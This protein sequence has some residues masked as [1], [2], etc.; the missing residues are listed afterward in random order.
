MLHTFGNREKFINSVISFL[1]THD[2]DGLDLFFLYPGLRNS[3]MH[4]RWNFLFLIEVSPVWKLQNSEMV[5][6]LTI[7][8]FM[9]EWE[10]KGQERRNRM[11]F[12][13]HH[14]GAIGPT[15]C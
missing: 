7:F 15:C 8:G 2:F 14:A 10:H 3:P 6:L 11:L 5:L 4:D 1:R 9:A 13:C 12:S